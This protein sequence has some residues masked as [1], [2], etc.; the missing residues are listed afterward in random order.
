MRAL[1][2]MPGREPSRSGGPQDADREVTALY[3]THYR[4]LVRM[5]ALLVQDLAAAEEIVQDS[6]VA[7]HAAWRRLPDA[8]HALSYLRRSVVDRSRAALRRH[9]VVDKL[10]PRL[11]PD[12]PSGPGEASIEVERSAFISALWTLPP[13]QREV[14]VLRYFAD[15]P[16]TQV[17]SATGISETA[18]KA[19]TARA[20]SSLRT[21]LRKAGS[22]TEA[23]AEDTERAAQNRSW[24]DVNPLP[25]ARDGQ[26]T[27]GSLRQPVAGRNWV[28]DVMAERPYDLVS[29]P[30]GVVARVRLR[31]SSVL[32]SPLLNRGTAF[33][34]AEREA[35]GLT[36]LL[37]EGVSTIEGQLRRVYGQYQRQPDDLAKN[38]YLAGLRDRNEVL[39]YRLLT[40]HIDEMLPI[41]YTP[42]IG[43]A[44]ERYSYEFGRPRGV[45]MSVDHPGQV[46]T[47]FRNYGLGPED[48]DLIIATDSEGILGIGDW[49]VGGIQIA[50]GKL[51]V[52]VAA[53]GLHPRRIIPV[54]L[55]AGTDNPAL[56][57]EEMYPGNRH[58]RVR[59]ERYDELIDTYVSVA[60]RHVPERAAALG[61]LRRGQRAPHPDQV[62][63]QLPDV[64]RR[65]PGHGRGGAGRR[66]R[67]GPGRGV[68]DA[69]PA[70]G[71]PRRRHGRDRDRG[72]PAAGDDRRGPQPGRSHP[73]FLRARQQRPADQRLP[74]DAAG[75]PGPLRPPGRGGQRLAAGRRGPDRAGRGGGAQPP[76]HADRDLDP[77]GRLHRGDRHRDGGARGAADHHAAVQ[78]DLAF[79]GPARRSHR[80]DRRAGRSSPPAARSSPSRTAA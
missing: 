69:R 38:L 80:L 55:D 52:Y 66:A 12:L 31:G 11:A 57:A 25:I 18:V 33:T 51:A 5:A 26:A 45:F 72:R 79:G 58:P 30:E 49:G 9:V 10:A 73:V 8:E 54:V 21:E 27:V 53:A 71:D 46:E 41:V 28:G 36:G 76:H 34:L 70:G 24:Q 35:L 65:H 77:A 48:V 6:F 16:E 60:T 17:A 43:T 2:T 64:Q 40:E 23:R 59:G 20:M 4:P 19:Y 15:L 61:G 44:I 14:V 68:A 67:R 74:G 3:L 22:A 1:K 39:F 47:A 13:R 63:R 42:T 37:P 75:L 56:L 62:R 29:T 78:P 50:M 7:V 32:V